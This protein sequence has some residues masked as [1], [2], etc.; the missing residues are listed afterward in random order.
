MIGA[1]G[2]CKG[3]AVSCSPPLL[4]EYLHRHLLSRAGN[5][6]HYV[7]IRRCRRIRSPIP[8]CLT[9][10]LRDGAWQLLYSSARGVATNKRSDPKSADPLPIENP[11]VQHFV[12]SETE[13]SGAL[14]R[15]PAELGPFR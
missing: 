12:W 15:T 4:H 14:P 6:K 11:T 2:P 9:V 8:A 5:L 13:P 1:Y 3:D 10:G 7:S